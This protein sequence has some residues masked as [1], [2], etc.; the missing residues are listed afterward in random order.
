MPKIPKFIENL[1]IKNSTILTVG[2]LIAALSAF[3]AFWDDIGGPM[4]VMENSETITEVE[5]A[6]ESLEKDATDT[7]SRNIRNDQRELWQVE[8]RMEEVDDAEKLELLNKQAIAL[9]EALDEQRA[10][11]ER[12]RKK[13]D[14]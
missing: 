10:R 11:K 4:P 7:Y 5:D 1:P 12:R 6:I 2:A 9:K 14:Q 8:Q 13:Q 3:I